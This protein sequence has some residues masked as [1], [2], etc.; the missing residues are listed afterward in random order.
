[1]PFHSNAFTFLFDLRKSDEMEWIKLQFYKTFYISCNV[2]AL[3]F[4]VD[5]IEWNSST[6][7]QFNNSTVQQFVVRIAAHPLTLPNQVSQTVLFKMLPLS[8]SSTFSFFLSQPV[9]A[10]VFFSVFPS[11]LSFLSWRDLKDSSFT[12]CYQYSYSFSFLFYVPYSLSPRLYATLQHFS[13]DRSSWSSPSFWS[14]T[15][16]NFQGVCDL[17][18]EVSKFQHHTA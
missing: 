7:Q 1:M 2:K 9:A 8:S 11:L 3:S 5:G 6:D 15:F 4:S 12:I 10:K 16:Q 14:T 18:P 13:R 17:F